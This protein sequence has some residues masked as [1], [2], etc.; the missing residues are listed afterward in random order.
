MI[1]AGRA[2]APGVAG[3]LDSRRRAGL[4]KARGSGGYLGL[5]QDILTTHRRYETCGKGRRGVTVLRSYL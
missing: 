1:T 5:R 2:M 4:T 3:K